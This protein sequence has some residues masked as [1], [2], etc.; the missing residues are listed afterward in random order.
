MVKIKRNK[1]CFLLGTVMC[2]VMIC[3]IYLKEKT[4][5]SKIRLI[6]SDSYY[7]DFTVL[8]EKVNI[9]CHLV[10]ENT[11]NSSKVVRLYAL[12]P[13]DL[14]NGLLKEAKLYAV[15]KKNRVAEFVI[16]EKEKKAID[17]TFIGDF[18]GNNQKISRALPQIEVEI[19]K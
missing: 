5:Q 19:V 1:V 14:E 16:D 2:M 11:Y 18:A 13:G 8:G 17:V 7:S 9:E 12:F 15:D 3:G 10:L 4:E 6:R